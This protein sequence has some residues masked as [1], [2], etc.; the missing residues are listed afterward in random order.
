MHIGLHLVFFGKS[1]VTPPL[2]RT[3]KDSKTALISVEGG[4]V[5]KE[6][7]Q[8]QL[9]RLF[10]GKWVWALKDHEENTFLTKFL[11]RWSC[12]RRLPLEALILRALGSQ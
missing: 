5:F 8:K 6:A 11:L 12:S 4:Q 9:E 2:S 1:G 7:V 3:R 10:L